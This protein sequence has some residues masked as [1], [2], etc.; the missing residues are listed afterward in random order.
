MPHFASTSRTDAFVIALL[1]TMTGAASAQPGSAP[2]I[3]DSPSRRAGEETSSDW[4]RFLGKGYDGVAV[5]A[6]SGIDWTRPARFMWSI[7]LGEG[8]GIGSV[9][10]GNF[11]QSDA[12][13]GR[14][15]SGTRERL[16]C[17]DLTTG[18]EKWSKSEPLSYRDI[19]GYENGPRSSPAIAGD[20]VITFGVAGQLVCRNVENGET[21]WSVDTNEKYGVVQNFFGVGSSPLVLGDV[22][23]V[24][25]GGSPAEDQSIAPGDLDRVSP[26]GSAVVAFD[27]ATGEERWKC[28]DDLASYS[29]PR[30]IVIDDETLV[31]VFARN[32]LLAI[33]PVQGQV[34]WRFDHRASILESVN[35]MMPV[36]DGDRVFISECYQVGSALLRVSK[37]SAQVVWQ[38]DVRQREKAMRCHWSTPILVDGYLYGCSGR[39]AP[40]SDFRCIEFSTGKV[41]W[42]DPRRTRSS[43]TRVGE[44]LLVMEERG[45][46]QVL[47]VNPTKMEEIAAWDLGQAEGDRPAL[48]SPCWSAP[49]VIGNQ[50]I[51]RGDDRVIS[52]S[53]PGS[54]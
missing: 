6:A 18:R 11:F 40:D 54:N 53:L 33:D 19:Y 39:N 43:V 38:D 5:D 34:R 22:V 41:Q 31:L 47:K 46:L 4:P 37:D 3:D 49:V 32:G 45:R 14:F 28:G 27:L 25:V 20:R 21:L 35:A 51:V 24:M 10:G 2:S 26:N 16:R 50:L 17:F 23:I 52:L 8:Y 30:P 44:H 15:G 7:E 42:M 9:A 12:E 36:V 13:G 1:L 48:R 29:S